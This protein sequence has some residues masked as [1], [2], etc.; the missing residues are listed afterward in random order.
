MFKTL[1]VQK[2]REQK[3]EE[4]HGGD[5]PDREGGKPEK[6]LRTAAATEGA[7]HHAERAG[8][9]GGAAERTGW[10]RTEVSGAEERG[11]GK[12]GESSIVD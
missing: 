4:R 9:E 8:E 7:R 1:K 11:G 2:E 10:A 5:N 6:E 3:R 12:G